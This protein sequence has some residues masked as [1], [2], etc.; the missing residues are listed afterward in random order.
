[1]RTYG[2]TAQPVSRIRP[3]NGT[4][5]LP[6]FRPRRV[7]VWI[8]Y[9][10]YQFFFGAIKPN[11][12]GARLSQRVCGGHTK[13]EKLPRVQYFKDISCQGFVYAVPAILNTNIEVWRATER[14]PFTVCHAFSHSG[15]LLYSST[16]V[17]LNCVE[18]CA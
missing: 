13:I 12:R 15:V 17:P 5:V 6:L 8:V 10:P 2:C 11:A 14:L 7:Y 4:H 9:T 1:M 16:V 18:K 3:R